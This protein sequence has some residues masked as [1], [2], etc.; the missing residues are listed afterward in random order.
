MSPPCARRLV[1]LVFP[2]SAAEV[3]PSSFARSSCERGDTET[4]KHAAAQGSGSR[5][6][7]SAG[8]TRERGQASPAAEGSHTWCLGRASQAASWLRPPPAVRRG[9]TL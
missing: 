9:R 8:R 1:A 4:R 2:A 5:Q 7:V 3:K 6:P